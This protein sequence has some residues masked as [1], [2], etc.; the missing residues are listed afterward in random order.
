[1]ADGAVIEQNVQQPPQVNEGKGDR[2]ASHC[3]DAKPTPPKMSL[4]ST[5]QSLYGGTRLP[6]IE[7]EKTKAAQDKEALHERR[8]RLVVERRATLAAMDGLPSS[9]RDNKRSHVMEELVTGQPATRTHAESPPIGVSVTPESFRQ[10]GENHTDKIADPDPS[11][12][13]IHELHET[14]LRDV[15]SY[16]QCVENL[17]NSPSS[18]MP[19]PKIHAKIVVGNDRTTTGP[20]ISE[21]SEISRSKPLGID[22]T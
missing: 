10:F 3:P 21:T 20:P 11:D 13:D 15:R 14:I 6:P 5:H 22:T 18:A 7:V 2:E 9:A 4:R 16:K 1:M 12:I 17:F 19:L 8:S